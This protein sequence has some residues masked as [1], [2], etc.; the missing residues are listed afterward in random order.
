MKSRF[1][2][3]A[4]G[5]MLLMLLL[6]VQATAASKQLLYHFNGT[7][8]DF[9]Q[10]RIVWKETANKMLWLYNRTDKSEVL[11]YDATGSNSAIGQAKLSAEGVVYSFADQ[12]SHKAVTQYW[13]DGEVRQLGD[14]DLAAVKGNF[15]V[16]ADRVVD[17]TSGQS[18]P[19]DSKHSDVSPDGSVVYATLNDLYKM[20][21][22]G[23]STKL[24]SRSPSLVSEWYHVPLGLYGPVSDGQNTIFNELMMV[25]NYSYMKYVTRLISADGTRT[26]LAINPWPAPGDYAVNNG[27]IAYIKYVKDKNSW[28]LNVRSPQGVEKQVF[29][30][31]SWS[32]THM[33]LS[34]EQFWPDGSVA[35]T[36]NKKT[37]YIYFNQTDTLKDVSGVWQQ[38]QYRE[39]IFDGPEASQFRFGAW[40][41]LD[42]GSL[43]GI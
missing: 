21:P 1:M 19:F 43:Y 6:P 29:E 36:L 28:I 40:Y 22:D 24:A 18:R 34:I 39:H 13:R 4:S 31:T 16:L 15:A 12:T 3:L 41:R 11:V 38:F 2:L 20:L 25:D 26:T 37:T 23:T 27:W 10:T 33:P 42:G 5:V 14:A 35:Y 32:P 17:L 30:T 8:A 9:D 7:I